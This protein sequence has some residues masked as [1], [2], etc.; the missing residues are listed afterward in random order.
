MRLNSNRASVILGSLSMAKDF[1]RRVWNCVGKNVDLF[2]Q[3]GIVKSKWD[4][5][6]QNSNVSIRWKSWNIKRMNYSTSGLLFLY[7]L[8]CD[9]FLLGILTALA[10]LELCY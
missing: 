8:M 9:Y 3:K 7:V 10:R 5:R 6:E 1:F 2:L 4:Y